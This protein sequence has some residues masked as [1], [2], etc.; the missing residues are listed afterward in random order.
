MILVKQDRL[1][2]QNTCQTRAF[3]LGRNGLEWDGTGWG[4]MRWG[5]MG[6]GWNVIVLRM[7]WDG[8]EIAL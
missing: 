8:V 3:L 6:V 4:G 1:P 7:G 2:L 5:E